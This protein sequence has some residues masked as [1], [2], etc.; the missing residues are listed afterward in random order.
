ML[1]PRSFGK[2]LVG[3]ALLLPAG[4]LTQTAVAHAQP[5]AGTSVLA[6][7]SQ[8]DGTDDGADGSE[9]LPRSARPDKGSTSGAQ[10]EEV[11]PARSLEDIR[12]ANQS[13]AS[14][15]PAKEPEY[16]PPLFNGVSQLAKSIVGGVVGAVARE[17]GPFDDD[18]G[19]WFN[20]FLQQF[21]S[22]AS[23]TAGQ[24][25]QATQ[26][27]VNTL[28]GNQPEPAA[29]APA[30][31]APAPQAPPDPAA[32]M[33]APQPSTSI[34]E[35]QPQYNGSPPAGPG[36][37]SGKQPGVGEADGPVPDGSKGKGAKP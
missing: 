2:V 1:K 36:H 23:Q 3:T 24:V 27:T 26:N 31:S 32:S 6:S 9:E 13:G 12:N 16:D 8:D 33:P 14:Q 25:G 18:K 20:L 29:S 7:Y 34:T 10:Y 28:T 21:L 5:S 30:Q 19:T 4:M 35:S 37:G 17:G 22:A 15:E 11:G